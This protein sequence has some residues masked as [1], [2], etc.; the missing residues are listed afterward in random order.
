MDAPLSLVPGSD[1]NE[2]VQVLTDFLETAHWPEAVGGAI[3]EL[4]LKQVLHTVREVERMLLS[5]GYVLGQLAVE[6]EKFLLR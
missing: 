4:L 5:E 1:R 2:P 6:A 3:E